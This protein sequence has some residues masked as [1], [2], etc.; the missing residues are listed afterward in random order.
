MTLILASN[1][2]RRKQL[3]A[4]T[5]LDFETLTPDVDEGVQAGEDAES[6]V[7]R[8]ADRKAQ[9]AVEQFSDRVTRRRFVIACDTAVVHQG[10][11]MG[12]PADPAQA[13][14]MLTRLR[15]DVHHVFSALTV[16]DVER[17]ITLQDVCVTDVPMRAYSMEEMIAYVLSGDPMDKAGAYAIQNP[18]FQPVEHLAG[19]YAN[20]MGLPLCH[21]TRT[22]R[23]VDLAPE[24][25]VPAACQQ[26]L[27]YDC[28][29]YSSILEEVEE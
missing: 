16:Q 21:L 25:D 15:G 24:V 19:C 9:V 10:E 12:K 20:V 26:A 22:L 11:I 4:L 5:G 13:I 2:P 1:S 23:R 28:P 14:I 7:R 6:Y 18:D 27:S 3:L 8:I 17:G 29:V